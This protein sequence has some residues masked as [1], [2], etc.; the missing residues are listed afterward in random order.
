VTVD[1]AV[2][3]SAFL[4]LTFEGLERVPTI[5][6]EVVARRLHIAPGGSGMQAIGAARLGLSAAIA[7]RM[8][9]DVTTNILRD[10]MREEGV[11]LWE[12][13]AVGSDDLGVPVS[14]LLSARG[15]VAMATVLGGAEPEERD[16]TKERCSA[17]VMSL[18]RL[19]LAPPGASIY[20][21]TGALEIAHVK[22]KVDRKG[23]ARALILNAAEVTALAD[24]SDPEEAGRRMT[25]YAETVVVTL[26]AE[27][28]V[29]VPADGKAVR[30][31]APVMEVVDATGAGD[32][33][34]AAYVW[35][36][37]HGATLMDA[38]AWA[39]LYA[40]LSVRA[41][42][43]FAGAVHLGELLAEGSA[44]GLSPPPRTPG[45]GQ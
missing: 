29:A 22:G 36:D 41:P 13:A 19:H 15:G 4:D 31:A 7:A 6:E 20:A 44:R 2:I 38:V 30:V 10:F 42:T 40:A 33:F 16:V 14:A 1:V 26:G 45:F 25:R 32:L 39:C 43:A 24:E 21:V 35:A 9:T 18:G 23:D 28:A 12:G 37:L 27:G 8:G 17:A 34:V 5:G 11:E 3:G